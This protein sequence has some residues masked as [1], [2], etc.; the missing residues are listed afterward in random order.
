MTVSFLILSL[1]FYRSRNP[2]SFFIELFI[3]PYTVERIHQLISLYS[4]SPR[5][6]RSIAVCSSEEK[7]SKSQIRVIIKKR[8][9]RK[10]NK[11]VNTKKKKKKRKK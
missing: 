9:R 5:S 1:Q 8:E 3:N 11:L 6:L 7:L 4:L 10:R 2:S